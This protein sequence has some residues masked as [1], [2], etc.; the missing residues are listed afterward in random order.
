M[1]LS[2]IKSIKTVKKLT[3]LES[4]F[5]KLRSNAEVFDELCA[6]FPALKAIDCFSSGVTATMND[7]IIHLNSA[8]KQAIGLDESLQKVMLESNRK[9]VFEQ[10]KKVCLFFLA[11]SVF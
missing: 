9:N 1:T 4:E 11:F 10:S 8:K 2:S 3:G 5:L 7:I 6:K